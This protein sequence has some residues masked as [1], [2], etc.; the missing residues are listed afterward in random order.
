MTASRF[1]AR[2]YAAYERRRWAFFR[3][4]AGR[5]C[6]L[7]GGIAW[8]LAQDHLSFDDVLSGPS[9][10]ALARRDGYILRH[11]THPTLDWCD[12]GLTADDMHLVAGSYKLFTGKCVAGS[13]T[14]AYDYTTR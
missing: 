9:H 2:D 12:D 11:H 3:S 6:L 13:M 5:A 10:G 8:R 4:P 14:A 1:S 7:R